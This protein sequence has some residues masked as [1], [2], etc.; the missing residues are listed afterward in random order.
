[1]PSDHT[2]APPRRQPQRLG[3]W[4]VAAL[5]L[6]TSLS[7]VAADWQ[8]TDGEVAHVVGI[9]SSD[10]A[11]AAVEVR[12][13]AEPEVRIIHP[14]LARV[15]TDDADQRPGW[16]RTVPLLTGWGLDLTRP[17]HHGWLGAWYR[18]NDRRDCLT[19]READIDYVFRSLKS[20][21]SV[22]VRIEPP[23]E[24]PVDLRVSLV[25]SAKAIEAVCPSP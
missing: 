25:G 5:L 2:L 10:G 13:E 16:R 3:A 9:E 12:C 23:G 4:L 19:P 17:D 14:A 7:A 22:F 20:G 15:P 1:M 6:A 24:E 21:W 8:V 11:D 18:C